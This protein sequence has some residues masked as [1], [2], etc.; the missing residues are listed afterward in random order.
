MRLFLTGASGF[1]GSHLSRMALAGGAQV[2]ILAQPE[3]PLT[4]LEAVVRNLRVFRGELGG[5]DSVEVALR[6]FQPDVLIH[7]AWNTEPGKYLESP[8]N[9]PL[10]TSSLRLMETAVKVEC[11]YVLMTGTCAEYDT[12]IGY[13]REDGP[14]RPVTLYAAAKHA[15][16]IVAGEIARAA[17]AG[18][19]WGRLFYLYGPGEEPRRL[20]PSVIRELRSGQV[21]QASSGKQVRDYLHVEDVASALWH[22]AANRLA[23]TYNVSS[24]MPTTVRTLLETVGEILGCADRIRF[25]E[26]PDREWEPRFIC[27]DNS[28]LKETHWEPKIPLRQGLEQTVR[29]WR[30]RA[31]G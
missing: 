30:E 22:L 15:L 2:G 24:G 26:A 20:V 5:G 19:G 12:E 8:E 13:L 23:G 7:L 18:F 11:P 17:G 27:G 1:V 21:F 25:G 31:E 6:E 14:T 9:V 29:W 10:L 16:H 28:R 3:D 4:R